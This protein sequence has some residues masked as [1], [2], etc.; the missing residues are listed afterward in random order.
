MMAEVELPLGRTGWRE[1]PSMTSLS[2]LGSC[3][4]WFLGRLILL[5]IL[6]LLHPGSSSFGRPF[7]VCHCLPASF[8]LAL[9]FTHRHTHTHTHTR[10]RA[11]VHTHTHPGETL[12]SSASATQIA[13]LYP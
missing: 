8:A 6:L 3:L 4:P 5:E 11:R 13:L 1:G 2:L 9:S 7:L 12:R 10:E